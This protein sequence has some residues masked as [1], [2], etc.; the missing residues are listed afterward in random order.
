M[1]KM[2]NIGNVVLIKIYLVIFLHHLAD[3]RK[4]CAIFMAEEDTKS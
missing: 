1:K 3:T 2:Q 4:N